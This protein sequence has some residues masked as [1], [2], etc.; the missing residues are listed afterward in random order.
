[1]QSSLGNIVLRQPVTILNSG[2]KLAAYYLPHK[3]S[4]SFLL[5]DR[6]HMKQRESSSRLLP[7]VKTLLVAHQ[8]I[9]RLG[10]SPTWTLPQVSSKTPEHCLW[11]K[12]SSSPTNDLV[13]VLKPRP[14]VPLLRLILSK[15][16]FLLESYTRTKVKSV[17]PSH[18]CPTSA[19][20]GPK[21]FLAG[22]L[23]LMAEL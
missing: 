20:L 8:G 2:S 13:C 22:S 4:P 10:A 7:D 11:R 18:V 14:C 5:L 15:S 1:M 3:A 23:F 16:I 21:Y 9:W 6:K 17:H 12:L 19:L